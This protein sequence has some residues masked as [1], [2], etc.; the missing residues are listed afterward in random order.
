MKLIVPKKYLSEHP[1]QFI[2]T[3]AAYG[4][5]HSKATGHDSFVRRLTRNFYPRLHMYIKDL[6]DNVEFNLH[7]DQKETSY[8]G[9]HMHNAEYEGPV[10]AEEMNRIKGLLKENMPGQAP[11]TGSG[12][13]SASSGR[14]SGDND[15]ERKVG[16][17]DYRHDAQKEEK[18]GFWSRLF[19]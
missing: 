17:G 14:E 18:K 1:E 3:K 9:N 2:R 8:G 4:H 16:H 5:I 13:P 6:G 11:S 7:I 12:R 10:V 19:G 15:T